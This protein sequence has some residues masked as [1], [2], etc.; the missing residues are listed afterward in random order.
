MPAER[1]S[2]DVIN[3]ISQDLPD[4]AIMRQG[5]PLPEVTE[6]P[7][8]SHVSVADSDEG[9]GQVAEP[10]PDSQA[11]IQQPP[12]HT[13]S[14]DEYA[15][16]QYYSDIDRRLRNDPDFAARFKSALEDQPTQP[17]PVSPAPPSPDLIPDLEFQDPQYK[18]LYDRLEAQSQVINRL[19]AYFNRQSQ[20]EAQAATERARTD[21][22]SRYNLT[23]EQTN[24][25]YNNAQLWGASAQSL[26]ASGRDAQTALN[27]I[28]DATAWSDPDFRNSQ[29]QAEAQ[30]QLEDQD[31]KAK[32][33]SLSG[34]SGSMPRT[35][36]APANESERRDAI[37]TA[38]REGITE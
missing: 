26:L 38:I 25:Y 20:I 30:R 31:R 8:E 37:I 14:D 3:Q 23:E 35:A 19:D 12:A 16:F 28:L 32:A 13:L 10:E 24:Q 29:I 18:A 6:Q 27:M 15:N 33:G 17:S 4:D 21:F 22:K 7:T 11:P 5:E 1:L 9:I 34:T 36:P 2:A